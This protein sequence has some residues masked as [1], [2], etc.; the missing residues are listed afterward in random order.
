MAIDPALER[1]TAAVPAQWRDWLEANHATAP[2]AVLVYFKKGSGRASITWSQ[3]VD[4]A[5]CFGWI[6]SKISPLDTDRYEQYFTRRR[7][8]SAWSQVN[9]AKI[10]RL[11]DEGRM[12]PSGWA[13]VE[14]ARANGAWTSLD[15]GIA[16]LLAADIE[17]ALDANVGARATWESWPPS[18]RRLMVEWITQA[19][20]PGTRAKRIRE[21]GE[22]AASGRKPLRFQ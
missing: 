12:A 19:K 21:L 2:A 3:A 4:E 7:P 20:R 1:V 6:D 11:A 16:D 14:T 9:K 10:G 18:F 13:A 15:E 17:A 5:L 22:Q 8:R